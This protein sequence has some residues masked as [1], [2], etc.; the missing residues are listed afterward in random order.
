MQD[1]AK[2]PYTR[3]LWVD[4]TAGAL[5]GIA[6]LLLHNLLSQ[7]LGL[8]KDVLLFTGAANILYACYSFSL[9]VRQK[10]SHA[11]ILMLIIANAAWVP[12]CLYLAATHWSTA[13]LLG[14]SH[15]FL[16]ALFVGSLA[17]LEWR[18]RDQLIGD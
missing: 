15:L 2:T 7:W 10:R 4:C 13:H 11:S 8:P 9:A 17:L 6:V 14:L 5:V 12:V 18:Y 16:E 1:T 3:L